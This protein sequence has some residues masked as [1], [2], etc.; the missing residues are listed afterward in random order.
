MKEELQIAI[1]HPGD[2]I[3][4]V[5]LR[6]VFVQVG[7]TEVYDQTHSDRDMPLAIIDPVDLDLAIK[8]ASD[9]YTDEN[10]RTASIDKKIQILL[11]IHSLF[12]AVLAI[13]S[14]VSCVKTMGK[15]GIVL[16]I[17][18]VILV[19]SHQRLGPFHQVDPED[20]AGKENEKKNLF[21]VYRTSTQHNSFRNDHLADLLRAS[22][23]YTFMALVALLIQAFL[24]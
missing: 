17:A 19:F 2:L 15:V 14:E 3:V 21:E 1:K 20:W 10:D 18:A 24:A 9:Q 4:W 7:L 13:I 16:I 11:A 22:Q 5:L 6:I 23:R 12:V 8:N